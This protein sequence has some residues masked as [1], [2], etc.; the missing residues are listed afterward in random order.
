M[1][2]LVA[3][4]GRCGSRAK[5]SRRVFNSISSAARLNSLYRTLVILFPELT[6]HVASS[7][8]RPLRHQCLSAEVDL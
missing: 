7:G 3:S 4:Q 6:T 1:V 8:R 5:R 2:R